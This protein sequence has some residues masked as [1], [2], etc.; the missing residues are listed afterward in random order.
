MTTTNQTLVPPC[1]AAFEDG[2]P[3]LVAYVRDGLARV[4]NE[5]GD[6]WAEPVSNLTQIEGWTW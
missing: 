3:V 1:Y 6:W 4:V 2:S 5:C